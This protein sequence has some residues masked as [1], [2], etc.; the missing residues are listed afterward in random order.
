MQYRQDWEGDCPA[1]P[2]YEGENEGVYEGENEGE[3]CALCNEQGPGTMIRDYNDE[4]IRVCYVCLNSPDTIK[5]CRKCGSDNIGRFQDGSFICY[6][7]DHHARS[8][9]YMIPEIVVHYEQSLMLR[10]MIREQFD[11]P[12]EK[13]TKR[14][15]IAIKRDIVEITKRLVRDK[16]LMPDFLI[17]MEND[18]EE[19]VNY[20]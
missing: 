14:E 8:D 12:F 17:E 18:L 5:V 15:H 9:F 7:C 20:G 4:P 16:H 6:G 11:R 10:R 3:T 2:Y 13:T 1:S 19:F